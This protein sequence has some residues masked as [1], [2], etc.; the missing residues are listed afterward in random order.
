MNISKARTVLY[1]AARILGDVSAVK[2]G[3]IHKRIARRGLGKV[4]SRITSKIIK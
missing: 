3:T 2:N 1:T 4:F